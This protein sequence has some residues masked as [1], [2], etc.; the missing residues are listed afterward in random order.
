M[1]ELTLTGSHG[2]PQLN[3]DCARCASQAHLNDTAS[4]SLGVRLDASLGGLSCCLAACPP[5]SLGSRSSSPLSGL[6]G[7]PVGR[8][9]ND[10]EL[11][12]PRLCRVG[13]VPLPA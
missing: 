12:L 7:L 3:I 1:Q 11:S 2:R 9:N 10:D 4:S 13:L 6:G 5:E 8:C